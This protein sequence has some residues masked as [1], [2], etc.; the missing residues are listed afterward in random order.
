M[1]LSNYIVQPSTILV[2]ENFRKKAME[3]NSV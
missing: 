2:L 1:Y 3:G